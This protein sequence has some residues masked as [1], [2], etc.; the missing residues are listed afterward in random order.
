LPTG[1]DRVFGNCTNVEKYNATGKVTS[2]ACHARVIRYIPMTHRPD[3]Q[4]E[5][6]LK[7]ATGNHS[8]QL[9]PSQPSSVV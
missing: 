9:P 8:H 2:I 5:S 3:Q 1:V 6:S 4:V 7:A